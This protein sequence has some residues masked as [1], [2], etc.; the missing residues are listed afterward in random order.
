MHLVFSNFHSFLL[1][2]SVMDKD[3]NIFCFPWKLLHLMWKNYAKRK[4]FFKWQQD[5]NGLLPSGLKIQKSLM[6]YSNSFESSFRRCTTRRTTWEKT[7][8]IYHNFAATLLQKMS[9]E[10]MNKKF[11]SFK[12][13]KQHPRA[14]KVI[15][16][17]FWIIF[18]S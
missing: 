12:K 18:T 2:C 4:V 17:S 13:E 8:I 6:K 14:N 10:G 3:I 1:S 16:Y 5:V 7:I 9:N 11:R 15:I